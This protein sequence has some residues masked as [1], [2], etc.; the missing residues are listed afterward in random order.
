MIEYDLLPPSNYEAEEAVLGSIMIDP[1]AI[2]EVA[3]FLTPEDFYREK[4]KWV[5]ETL[6]E[7]SRGKTPL[8]LITVN[9]H[10]RSRKVLEE[11]GVEVEGKNII[12]SF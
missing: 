1:D 8:D 12:Y 6:L 9:N 5:Y 10:L 3:H 2:Y 7:L 11:V 4:N